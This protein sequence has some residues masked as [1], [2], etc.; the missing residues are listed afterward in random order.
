MQV[1]TYPEFSSRYPLLL[2][3]FMKRPLRMYPDDIGVVYR[4][5]TGEYQRFTWRQW[6][7]RTCQLAHALKELGVQPGRPGEPGDRIGAMALNHHRHLELIYAGTCIGAVSHPINVVLSREHMVHTINHAGD[8]IIFVDDTVFPLLELIYD[9]IKS[10]VKAFVYMSD[11]PGK[12]QTRV[13]PLY[14]YEDLLRGQPEDFEWPHLD[15]DT[16][17]VLYYTTGTTGI[18]KGVMFTHR[19]LYLQTIHLVADITL[20]LGSVMTETFE[21]IATIKAGAIQNAMNSGRKWE[22]LFKELVAEIPVVNVPLINIPLFHIH[23]WGAPWY[24]VLSAS[25]MVFPGRFSP[26]T[27]C[28]VVQTERVTSAALVP[29]ML[30]MLI[31]YEDLNKYDLSSLRTI[32]VGGAALPRG[33]KEKAERLFPSFR[34]SSGYG[35][36]ETAGP[37]IMATLKRYMTGW[38]KAE[39]DQVRVKTGLAATGIEVQVVGEDGKPVPHDNATLGEIVLRGHWILEQY[40]KDPEKTQTAWRDG[41]FHTGDMAKVDE[42]GYIIIADRITDVIR[43]GAEMVPTVLLENLAATCE[44]VLEATFVGVPDEKWGERP[45]ALV[46][47]VPGSSATEDDIYKFLNDE[48]VAKGKITK[49]MLPD[50]IAICDVIPKTSVGKYDKIAIRRELDKFLAKAK[51]MR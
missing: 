43:S 8:K 40:Y 13:E 30:A 26:Q 2:T 32:S 12:P 11:R 5:D 28:E 33:L 38:P 35:M 51:K 29:T 9:Q 23:A 10:T 46:K 19:Q 21:T 41:W 49:W 37:A 44:H 14:L 24:N 17:A 47:L 7:K 15:E 20:G 3:S 34:I 42:D 39:K 36:T 18:P 31:E 45:M 4:N 22:D 6:Y 50:Y 48:G 16:Y 1:K 27:F 25:K